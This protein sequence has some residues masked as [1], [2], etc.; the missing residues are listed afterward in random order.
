MG[1]TKKL[2]YSCL[3]FVIEGNKI[4]DFSNTTT[5]KVH[6]YKHNVTQCMLF[7]YN[8]NNTSIKKQLHKIEREVGMEYQKE[9][10]QG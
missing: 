1:R 6:I 8:H 4:W 9:D 3:Q 2:S 10:K 5:L 7:M